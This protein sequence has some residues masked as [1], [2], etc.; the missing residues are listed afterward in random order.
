MQ[1]DQRHNMTKDSISQD[2]QSLENDPYSSVPNIKPSDSPY[3]ANR[4]KGMGHSQKN[5]QKA[6][7]N[8]GA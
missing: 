4:A 8:Q 7:R 2:S 3:V 5:P 1:N 6:A